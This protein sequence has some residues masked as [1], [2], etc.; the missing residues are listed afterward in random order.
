MSGPGLF[1]GFVV[2]LIIA[3]R[4]FLRPERRRPVQRREDPRVGFRDL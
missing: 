3:A 2:V 4:I 1:I